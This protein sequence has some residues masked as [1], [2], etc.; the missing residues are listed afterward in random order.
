[1]NENFLGVAWQG[2]HLHFSFMASPKSPPCA[3]SFLE[4]AFPPQA[5]CLS[6]FLSLESTYPTDQ[7]PPAHPWILSLKWEP[8][9]VPEEL[10]LPAVYHQSCCFCL[11]SLRMHHIP[12]G[13]NL[14]VHF[15]IKLFGFL[16]LSC[17]N[18]LYFFEIKPFLVASFV[19]I[20]CQSIGCL[21]ILFMVSIVE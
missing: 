8:P 1:M 12:N 3:V 2:P 9:W 20:F 13:F 10:T 5:V 17:M 14:C 11:L 19:N 7:I 4:F 15:L 6:H 16:L 18:C 21:L